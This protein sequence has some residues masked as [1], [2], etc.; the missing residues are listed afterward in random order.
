EEEL[1]LDDLTIQSGLLQVCK[2]LQFLHGDARLVHSNLVPASIL[3]DARGDWK[4]GGLGFACA[5]GTAG[6]AYEHDYRMPAGTQPA[7]DYQAP[8]R[9]LEGAVQPAGDVF[10]LGCVAVAAHSGASPIASNN[11]LGAYRSELARMDRV[12]RVAAAVPDALAAAVRAVLVRAPAQRA[13]LT[14]FQGCAYFDNVLVATLRFLETLV[15]QPA[16]QK[17]A[18]LRGLP[19]VLPQFPPRVVRRTLLP[20]LLGAADDRSLVPLV[21]P[22]VFAVVPQLS[23]GDFAAHALPGLAPLLTADHPQAAAAVLEHI[24]LLQEKC[25]ADDFAAH[26]LP[27][28]YA[29]LL[30]VHPP[31]QTRA[32]QAAPAVARAIAARELREGL[33]PRVQHVYAKASLLEH[34]VRALACLHQLLPSLDRTT[35]V[36]KILPQLRRTKTREPAVVMAMLAMYEELG[37]NHLDRRLIA[38]DVLPVLWAQSVDDRLQPA[39]FDRFMHVVARLSDRVQTEHR[40]HLGSARAADVQPAAVAAASIDAHPG[41]VDDAAFEAIVRGRSQPHTPAAASDWAWDAPALAPQPAA[42]SS[43]GMRVEVDLMSGNGSG[44]DDDFG[45]FA[46]FIPPPKSPPAKQPAKQ[47]AMSLRPAAAAAR[48]GL[49]FGASPAATSAVP[50]LRQKPLVPAVTRA[51]QKHAGGKAADLGDFDP[52][53]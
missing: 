51:A 50:V 27:A 35:I 18:F 41:A 24:A 2:A 52:F 42:A 19:R 13:S 3:I 46:S 47:P 26:V 34:K 31:V 53:A 30:S 39:Q 48:T 5:T 45:T 9:A 25:S 49:Q 29:A 36:D 44:G 14:Q 37:L 28:L 23:P 6:G 4:L 1:E 8:E 38:T 16:G 22:A 7:L 20:R 11:D 40:R 15:E 12:D 33:L 21:L 17:A 43:Q 32:L 10:A